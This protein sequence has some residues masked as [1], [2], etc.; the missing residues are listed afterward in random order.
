MIRDWRP[1]EY[2]PRLIDPP[3]PGTLLANDRQLWRVIAIHER[4]PINWDDDER[5]RMAWALESRDRTRRRM[6]AA[7][8]SER[9][10][11]A[12]ERLVTWD[13]RPET[14]PNRPRGLEVQPVSGGK[15]RHLR[16]PLRRPEAWHQVD[17][18]HAVCASC[19]ELYPCRER[20]AAREAAHQMRRVEEL[21]SVGPGCC[22]HCRE[23]I[24]S[25][26]VARTFAGENLLLPGAP[27][28]AFHAR[29]TG[30]C[31]QAADSYEKR[32]REANPE[33]V[34]TPDLFGGES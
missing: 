24:T 14:W 4:D 16:W 19:G 3:E 7:S 11:E 20:D 33:D 12:S 10:G 28:P 1:V 15:R 26:Q 6:A 29:W 2:S 9:F 23:P 27:P 13:G 25:R 18:H 31:R 32:W 34:A 21:M 5:K 30:G 8:K 17:E 22:W